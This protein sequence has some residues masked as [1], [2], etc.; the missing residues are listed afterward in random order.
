M[1]GV[2]GDEGVL[3]GGGGELV[4][5]AIRRYLPDLQSRTGH[6]TPPPKWGRGR[7]TKKQGNVDRGEEA[8]ATNLDIVV[9]AGGGKAAGGGVEVEAEHRLLVVP[10]DLQRPAPH[11]VE[12]WM[13]SADRAFLLDGFLLR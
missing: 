7:V 11:L 12:C 8:G 6:G 4:V 3:E 13:G 2:I 5:R 1:G 9:G 10:V